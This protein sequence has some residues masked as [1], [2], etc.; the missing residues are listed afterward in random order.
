MED[1][2]TLEII[3]RMELT[4]YRVEWV[5]VQTPNGSFLIG[6]GHS[7]LASLLRRRGTITYKRVNGETTTLQAT[8]G[9]VTV[10]DDRVTIILD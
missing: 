10:I 5:E 6:P 1:V 8:K 3:Q 9:T 4:S 7:P 2:V